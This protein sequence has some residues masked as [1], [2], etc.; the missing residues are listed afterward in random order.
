[1]N[2]TTGSSSS[3]RIPSTRRLILVSLDWTREKDPRIPLGQASLVASLRASSSVNLVPLSFSLKPTEFRPEI[4]LEAILAHTRGYKPQDIDVAFGAYVWNE[5]TLQAL[6]PALRARGFCGRIILGGPQISY[7]GAGLEA[8]YP[9]ADVF[10]RG[11]GEDALVALA[12]TSAPIVHRG[13]HF[14]GTPDLELTTEV[15]LESLPSPWLTSPPAQEQ[16]FVRWETQRGCPFRCTFCQHRQPSP[17]WRPQRFH[18]DRIGQ[19]LDLLVGTVWDVAVLDPIFNLGHRSITLLNALR[20]RHFR[21][22]LSLQCRFETLTPAFL[23]ACRGLNVRLEFGL[24]T[25]HEREGR[26]IQRVN[27]LEKVRE[28]LQQIRSS[29]LPFEVSII[30]GLPEQTL[31][32]FRETV[33]FCLSERIPVIKAFPLQLLRGTPLERDRHRWQLRE[34]DAD[35]PSVIESS[36]FTP[37]DWL[38]MARLARA[39]DQAPQLP[40]TLEALDRSV[41]QDVAAEHARRPKSVGLLPLSSGRL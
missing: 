35:I 25:I 29:G 15:D 34:N 14:A 33:A 24:Q 10:V 31:E 26:T 41:E 1:M 40:R 12:E 22:R 38:E 32:S 36:T 37:A 17:T 20:E 5:R 9:Q 3:S 30:Y 16:R 7:T 13:V 21:G 6:L 19:E 23:D 4:A 8:L 28:G 39:L 27:S 2:S 18:P 11:Y